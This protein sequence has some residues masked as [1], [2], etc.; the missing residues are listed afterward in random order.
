[1]GYMTITRLAVLGTTLTFAAILLALDGHLYSIE[2]K[3]LFNP[4]TFPLLVISAS[5]LA[6]LS[7]PTM[8]IVGA[9]RNGAV[10]SMILFEIVWLQVLSILFLAGG[11]LASQKYKENFTNI[12]CSEIRDLYGPRDEPAFLDDLVTAC[13]EYNATQAFCFLNWVI[14]FLYTVTLVVFSIVASSRGKPVWFVSVK[15]AVFFPPAPAGAT[16][17]QTPVGVVPP[18]AQVVQYVQVPV[19]QGQST[20]GSV[21]IPPGSPAQQQVVYQQP[22]H[23]PGS[24]QV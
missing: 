24:A 23:T 18:G 17:V 20:G 1:M 9:I 22:I 4:D 12:D 5:G 7:I 10:T 2:K 8:L 13:H 3:W 21:F 15:D 16:I 11:A 19:V 6:F 14:L